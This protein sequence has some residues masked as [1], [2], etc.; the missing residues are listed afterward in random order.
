MWMLIEA[1]EVIAILESEAG[2]TVP[3][4]DD[5]ETRALRKTLARMKLSCKRGV[6]WIVRFVKLPMRIWQWDIFNLLMANLLYHPV[7]WFQCVGFPWLCSSRVIRKFYW[8]PRFFLSFHF[9]EN[10]STE[11]HGSYIYIIKSWTREEFVEMWSLQLWEQQFNSW[12]QFSVG[13]KWKHVF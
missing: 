6:C 4:M 11:T 12:S 5:R 3:S 13:K 10:I 1:Q 7:S 8:K 2:D 9:R